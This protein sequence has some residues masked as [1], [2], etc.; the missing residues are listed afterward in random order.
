VS[1]TKKKKVLKLCQ[2]LERD[3][4]K[5]L[6]MDRFNLEAI[7]LNILAKDNTH[8]ILVKVNEKFWRNV[9]FSS[10]SYSIN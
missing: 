3:P 5:L 8:Q 6:T 9:K 1:L 7:P 4:S 10:L 2:L